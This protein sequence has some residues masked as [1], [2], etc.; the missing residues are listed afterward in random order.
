MSLR[1]IELKA[2][3]RDRAH[4]LEVCGSLGATAQGDIHQIDTY[5]NVPKGRLKLREATPGRT[6]LVAYER[7]DTPGA[8]GCD[9]HLAPADPTVKPLLG[10]A[11]GIRIAVEKRRTL[12]LWHNV[13]IHLDQVN[14]LGDFIEFEAVLDETHD[15]ADGQ[16]KLAQL[17]EAFGLTDTD[18]QSLS[19]L[20]LL[21]NSKG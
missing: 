12:Y 21:E 17:C 15:D 1:N 7:S 13:R 19:Y 3:L 8:R 6:E 9:Y 14:G 18:H 2:R 4:A 16:E 10:A 20:E 11:L 5:F